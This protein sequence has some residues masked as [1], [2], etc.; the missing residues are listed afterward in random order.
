MRI[1]GPLLPT[2]GGIQTCQP[3]VEKL[4]SRLLLL[5]Y[6]DEMKNAAAKSLVLR[7]I[8]QNLWP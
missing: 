7:L 6:V 8:S 2:G 5:K 1:K 3:T 4:F